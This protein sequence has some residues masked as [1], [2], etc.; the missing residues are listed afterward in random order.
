MSRGKSD[1]Y[2][3][4]KE[5]LIQLII[6]VLFGV[7]GFFIFLV[8]SKDIFNIKTLTS[9]ISLW[10][11]IGIFIGAYIFSVALHELGHFITFIRNGIKMRALYIMFLLFIKKNGK[12]SFRFRFNSV[13]LGGGVAIPYIPKIKSEEELK[14]YQ[15]SFANSIIAAPIV[16]ILIPVV[17]GLITFLIGITSSN[18]TLKGVFL[19]I[20]I[21]LFIINS[22]LALSC[23]IKNELA[24]G[25]FPAYKMCK[26][27][28]EFM[29]IMLQQYRTMQGEYESKESYLSTMLNEYIKEEFE[30]KSL[31]IFTLGVIGNSLSITL[32]DKGDILSNIEDYIK[33]FENNPYV[34]LNHK[35]LGAKVVLFSV[36]EYLA[37]EK[38]EY[39]RAKLLYDKAS[40]TLNNDKKNEIVDYHIKQCEHLFGISDNREFLSDRRNI[41]PS[42]EWP[43][44]SIFDEYYEIEESI[45]EK[46]FKWRMTN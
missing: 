35:F 34:L 9:S 8:Y 21:S 11:K 15:K 20:T 45:N 33:Y 12:W 43:I 29:A 24:I 2:S 6:G 39:H 41:K 27:D 19:F 17:F 5:T 1:L 42:E 36:I 14:Y 30:S 3:K 44:W 16:T 28:K 38:G 7:L 46:I 10:I 23:L 26:E 25:D 40:E 31:N 18:G 22:F 37:I 13:M 4:K 32:S